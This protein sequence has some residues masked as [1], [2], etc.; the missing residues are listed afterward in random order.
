MRA[1]LV[2]DSPGGLAAV[3]ELGRAGWT[4]GVANSQPRGYAAASRW[5]THR[6]SLPSLV[7]DPDRFIAAVDLAVGSHQYEVVFGTGDAEVLALSAYRHQIGACVPYGPHFQVIRAF[8]KYEITQLARQVGLGAP[9]TAIAIP[10][11][12]PVFDPPILVKARLHWNPNA[13]TQSDRIKAVVARTIQEASEAAERMRDAGREPI[14]QQHI[15]GRALH[16]VAIT[17]A[18]HTVVSMV[19]HLTTR[20]GGSESG[21]SARAVTIALD[22]D[23]RERV[24]ALL[25]ELE[26]VGLADLQ[27]WLTKDGRALLSDFNGRIYGGLALPYASGMRPMDTWARLATGR[28]VPPGS[29]PTIG[30]RY[31]ALEGDLKQAIRQPDLRGKLQVFGV[32]A[33]AHRAVHPISDWSDARPTLVYLAR[34]PGRIRAKLEERS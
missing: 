7:E 24:R 25:S 4:V 32:L 10:G 34:L 2:G 6:H 13:P 30:V 20:L 28:K 8:D 18:D 31:Q 21:Q 33:E 26:W 1:L 15:E 9:L 23:L 5:T 14:F 16:V 29:S 22:A 11:S 17:R 27:F 19:A 3:R 12:K